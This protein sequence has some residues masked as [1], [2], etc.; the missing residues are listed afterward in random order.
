METLIDVDNSFKNSEYIY[1]S[2]DKNNK[3]NNIPPPNGIYHSGYGNKCIFCCI[4]GIVTIDSNTFKIRRDEEGL[5]S[6]FISF[7]LFLIVSSIFCFIGLL[8]HC[9][10]SEIIFLCLGFLVWIAFLVFCCYIT[11]FNKY[12]KLESNSISIIQKRSFCKPRITIY[13]YE[14][15]KHAAILKMAGD[16]GYDYYRFTLVHKSDER[17]KILDMNLG[18]KEQ[19]LN[20]FKYLADIIN[21]HIKN[22]QI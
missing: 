8:V 19:Q 2:S 15:L 11:D 17:I 12:I 16:D 18:I 22:I 5:N 7:F 14:E 6:F 10:E 4:D 1:P 21:E 3:S 20:Y 9:R 13:R